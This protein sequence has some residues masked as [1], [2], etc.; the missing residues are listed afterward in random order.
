MEDKLKKLVLVFLLLLIP[1]VSAI[2]EGDIISQQTLNNINVSNIN[3]QDLRCN[4]NSGY[5][6]DDD[7]KYIYKLFDCLEVNQIN[8]T[9]YLIQ[10]GYFFTQ[11]KVSK[12]V[13]CLNRFT[14]SQCRTGFERDVRRQA[15]Q[16]VELIKEQIVVY[17]TP[18][19]PH[20]FTLRNWLRTLNLFGGG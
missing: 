11:T 4:V 6:I 13:D 17:Q 14:L 16:R 15:I 8:E 9:H 2:D 3:Y 19:D 1:L 5:E 12:I 20:T 7:R 10:R 18:E